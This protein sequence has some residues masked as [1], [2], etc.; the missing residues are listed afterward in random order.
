MVLKW[1]LVN[2]RLCLL[3]GRVLWKLLVLHQLLLVAHHLYLMHEKRRYWYVLAA[4]EVVI[5]HWRLTCLRMRNWDLLII[6]VSHRGIL[7]VHHKML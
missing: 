3:N 6:L 4:D 7:I 2:H 5:Y 1:G